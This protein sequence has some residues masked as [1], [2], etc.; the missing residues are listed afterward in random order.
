M[1]FTVDLHPHSRYA[2]GCSKDLILANMAV[3]AK[4]KGIE[5]VS[6][7]DFTHRA[8]LSE[9]ESNRVSTQDG[10]FLFKGVR[11]V[12]GSEISCVYKQ[13]LR[14]RRVHMLVYAPTFEV[15]HQIR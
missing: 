1:A 6:T 13:G 3:W 5:L 8:W 12:L 14:S 10:G 11:F 7:S 9:L 4:V 15:V 2:Y